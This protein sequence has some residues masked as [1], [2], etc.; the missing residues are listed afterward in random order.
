MHPLLLALVSVLLWATLAF[1]GLK[2][3][4]L[5]PFLLVGIALCIGALAS[6]HRLNEW[7]TVTPKLLALGVFGLFG[8]HFFLFV[9][10]RNAP[11]IEANLINYLWPLLIVVLA[12]L[13]LPGTILT[14][15][16][17]MAAL[18]GFGGAA[19]LVTGG[20]LGF[21]SRYL[22]GYGCALTSAF[23][24]STYSL[25][26]K[27]M[28]DFPTGAVGAFCLLSG[29]LSLACHALLEP[30]VVPAAGDWFWLAVIGIG[31]M[32]IAFFTWDA[33]MKRGDARAIGALSYLTPLLST[34]LLAAT[35][36]GQLNVLS[37]AAMAL[38]VGG[39]V[40]GT[41]RQRASSHV[42]I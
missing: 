42:S 10:L 14:A 11:P 23:I 4:H 36:A 30:R 13:I 40:L 27:R 5:P 33:A 16:H 29:L 22:L 31:P 3:Q 34:V 24:W 32:G 15:R 26:T 37:L 20:K 25:A 8:F 1:L 19:L 38:I 12:P 21:D 6:V 18:L 35:G 28:G 17:I 2:L 39:A 9:A 7:R 41:M